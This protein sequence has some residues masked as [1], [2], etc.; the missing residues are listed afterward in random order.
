MRESSKSALSP[1]PSSVTSYAI[2][3]RATG[4]DVVVD[5]TRTVPT[6]VTVSASH[7]TLEFDFDGAALAAYSASVV[8]P[9]RTWTVST[10]MAT[11]TVQVAAT[12]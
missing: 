8:A 6:G 12:P 3:R 5:Q 1:S 2:Y 10:V 4:G 7:A 9:N 11:G